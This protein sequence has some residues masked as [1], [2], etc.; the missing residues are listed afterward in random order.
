ML[1]KSIFIDMD[2]YCKLGNDFI[3]NDPHNQTNNGKILAGI[4]RRHG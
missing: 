4:I 1:G 2:A 3:A